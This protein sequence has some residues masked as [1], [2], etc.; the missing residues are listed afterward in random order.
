[1]TGKVRLN[2]EQ[3]EAV[4]HIDGPMMVIAGPGSGKT[5][6]LIE[7]ICNL[8]DHGVMPENIL[9]ITF[10]KK[11][12]QEMEGRFFK[13][14]EGKSCPV[15]F[16]T[17]H[18]VF[19]HILKFHGLYDNNS[20]L[21]LKEKQKIIGY[22]CR[23]DRIKKGNVPAYQTEMLEKISLYK[24]IGEA[25][26]E[27][28]RGIFFDD[29]E[30][31][32]FR[33]I[34]ESYSEKCKR[35][36]KLDFDDMVSECLALFKAHP[37]K[38]DIWTQKYKYILVDEFQDINRPQYEILKILEGNRHNVFAVGDDD[39]SIYGFRGSAPGIMQTFI[40]EHEGMKTVFLKLN[41]R[42][43]FEIVE[44]ADKCIRNNRIRIDRDRQQTLKNRKKGEVTAYIF[45]NEAEESDYIVSKIMELREKTQDKIAIIYRSE[46]C[47]TLLEEKIRA[48]GLKYEKRS[49][50]FDF[51]G[52]KEVSAIISYM[53][54]ATL[55]GTLSDYLNILNCPDRNLSRD[56][57][58]DINVPPSK[59][60]TKLKDYY[61]ETLGYS[62]DEEEVK[63]ISRLL[64]DIDYLKDL[65]LQ[66]AF[67]YILKGI[68]VQ[69]TL[70]DGYI[71]TSDYPRPFDELMD[72]LK[73]RM[74]DFKTMEGFIEHVSGDK[75]NISKEMGNKSED[76]AG[77]VFITA[78]AS[79]GIEY[80]IV[81]VAGLQEGLFPHSKNLENPGIEEERRLFYVA[82]TR[83]KDRLYL[84][85]RGSVHGKLPS[86][87]I[88]EITKDQSFIASNSSLSRN[89]SNASATAS[90][91]S[92]SSI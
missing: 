76:G 2:R 5:F 21:T 26:F 81:F 83:A 73:L 60:L 53:K 57:F 11:A 35:D 50:F 37:E 75:E 86:R 64:K 13:R 16:G 23:K 29:E 44:A 7:R 69:K 28:D 6:L 84:C 9:V 3:A 10:S 8:I 31:K 49:K 55:R 56:A 32:E 24:N 36:R 59:M 54:I 51:Y 62:E 22:L 67:I 78:H 80:P 68:G 19:F 39:Q 71:Q 30:I 15:N 90:Y 88:Y 25:I 79:K 33:L 43:A 89:S 85:G 87:F 63:S 20:L 58:D 92:S 12:A 17:F 40:D 91:S 27:Q 41:Y 70:K 46:H 66:A 45:E 34:Y 42:S 48:S 77:I 14:M 65:P 82:L 74:K 61:I 38:A 52:L 47:V 4:M 18:A 1:M 72:D